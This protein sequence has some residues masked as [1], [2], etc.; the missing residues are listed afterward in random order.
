VTHGRPRRS[1]RALAAVAVGALLLLVLTWA[2]GLWPALG[3]ARVGPKAAQATAAQTAPAWVARLGVSGLEPWA[4]PNPRFEDQLSL[5]ADTPAAVALR[6][7]VCT[8]VGM[9]PD[10][11]F[12]Q[13]RQ[14]LVRNDA[15]L[16]PGLA[17]R[18]VARSPVIV[19]AGPSLGLAMLVGLAAAALSL[20]GWGL[21]ATK[22]EHD[23]WRLVGRS[24]FGATRRAGSG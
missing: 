20:G 23:R 21:W 22:R 4:S 5:I 13:V 14:A 10:R 24:T 16:C 9:Q 3:E 19:A 18:I 11:A 12:R 7:D 17:E 1:S 8:G 6:H 2:L 15:S